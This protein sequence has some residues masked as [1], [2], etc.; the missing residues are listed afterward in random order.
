MTQEQIEKYIR[1][2][3][4]RGWPAL[5]CAPYNL[6]AADA[7]TVYFESRRRD[8]VATLVAP[9]SPA[10]KLEASPVVSAKR[11]VRAWKKLL[12]PGKFPANAGETTRPISDSAD[13]ATLAVHA[14]AG[15]TPSKLNRSSVK[16]CALAESERIR[17][18]K[19][20]RVSPSFVKQVEAELE[21]IIRGIGG[22]EDSEAPPGEWDFLNRKQISAR[23]FEQLNRAVRKI[24]LRKVR[25]YP[26]KGQTLK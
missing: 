7:S 6:S 26:S 5:T 1:I 19:F 20:K 2:G 21:N 15:Y 24:I 16:S 4:N 8:A 23:V 18:G 25:S 9:V 14:A 11:R 3:R 12:K 22:P 17:A 13:A 10:M